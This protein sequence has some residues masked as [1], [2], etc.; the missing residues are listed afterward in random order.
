MT[1]EP[2][3]IFMSWWVEKTK[4]GLPYCKKYFMLQQ[5]HFGNNSA[6]YLFPFQ[7]PL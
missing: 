6:N 4:K 7:W 1:E 2:L 3:A 5:L